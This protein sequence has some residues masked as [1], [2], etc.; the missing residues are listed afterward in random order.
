MIDGG[1][2]HGLG[3]RNWLT[4]THNVAWWDN[5]VRQSVGDEGYARVVALNAAFAPGSKN[6]L[7]TYG[8]DGH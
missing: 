4:D 7:L 2:E 1:G 6:Y 5:A 3:M 8:Y